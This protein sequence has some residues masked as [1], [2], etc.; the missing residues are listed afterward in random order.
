MKLKKQKENELCKQMRQQ[1]KLRK[2]IKEK[3]YGGKN[4]ES[5]TENR[6]SGKQDKE[7]KDKQ[8]SK[9]KQQVMTGWEK[10]EREEETERGK[11]GERIDKAVKAAKSDS[12][13]SLTVTHC[14]PEN[15]IR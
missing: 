12:Q 1:R 10:K 8:K 14:E 2:I 3:I 9:E 6:T 4:M 11:A 13:K 7:V 15:I 5:D